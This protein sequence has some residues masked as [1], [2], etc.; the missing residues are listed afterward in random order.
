MKIS[1]TRVMGIF[2]NNIQRLTI[3][4]DGKIIDFKI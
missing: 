2:G 4:L 1:K 3:E